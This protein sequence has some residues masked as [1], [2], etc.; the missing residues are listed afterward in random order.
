MEDKQKPVP[1][2]FKTQAEITAERRRKRAERYKE[3]QKQ[4]CDLLH[5]HNFKTVRDTGKHSYQ[6]CDGCGKRRVVSADGGYQ[7]IDTE[8][9]RGE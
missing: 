2:I 7:P 8:W 5:I 4:V 6:Q 1:I 3:V 9:L